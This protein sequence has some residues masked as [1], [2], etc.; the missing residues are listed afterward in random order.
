MELL[1]SQIRDYAWGSRE[2]IAQLQGRPSPSPG[3]EAEL[4]LGA[5]PAAPSTVERNGAPVSLAELIDQDP[6]GW[7]GGPTAARFDGRLPYLMKVLAARTPLS[8]QAHP[9]AARARERYAAE[10]SGGAESG[11][12]NY[13]DPYHKPELLVAISPFDALC[14]F[15]DPARSAQA[16]AALR[17]DALEPVVKSLRTGTG[18]LP[19]AIETLLGWPAD[20]RAALV[21]AAVA[22]V[23]GLP[24]RYAADGAL[25]TDL[26]AH[27]PADPGVLVAL[28]LNR[29]R[30]APGEAV[31][32]PAGNLHAYLRGAGIEIMA[33]SD[34]VLRGGLTP[35]RVDV[36]ELLRVLRFDV[37]D[38][39]VVRPR[40][41]APGV[42]TWPVPAAE[43]SLHRVVLDA[44]VPQAAVAAAGP[45][46]VLCLTG[47][48][49]VDDGVAAVAVPPGQAAVGSAR[50]GSLTI[51]GA[52]EAFVASVNL[53]PA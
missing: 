29:V 27:Y 30:L 5:H 9:D 44:D 38:E 52:G 11:A 19:E 6:Q 36:A 48:V 1:T 49:T 39:P 42:I 21:A 53:D 2:V 47:A 3:P 24:A 15:R 31:W 8:L 28:L 50:P 43:F 18:G 25:L 20:D 45:R 12:R 26:A 37:L 35:K 17:L 46:V 22:A 10:R 13:V 33:A 51:S 4:W 7:L 16:V 40:S 14:G 32:M 23:D 41:V 34:N